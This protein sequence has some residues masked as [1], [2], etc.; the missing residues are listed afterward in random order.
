M[1]NE[2]FRMSSDSFLLIVPGAVLV[3]GNVVQNT[4]MI[5][6]A[7]II[8]VL[9]LVRLCMKEFHRKIALAFFYICMFTFLTGGIIIDYFQQNEE[10]LLTFTKEEY[11]CACNAL[12]I[13]Y[14]FLWIGYQWYGI[15]KLHFADCCLSRQVKQLFCDKNINIKWVQ[16]IS[17]YLLI[18]STVCMA[19]FNMEKLR[20]AMANGYMS[21]YTDY[22]G[23]AW[24]SR[25]EFVCQVSFFAGLASKPSKKR[26]YGISMLGLINPVIE[27]MQGTRGHFVTKIL[28][29]ALYLYS[30]DDIKNKN[31][32]KI[33]YRKK[34]QK[35]LAAGAAAC[36]AGLPILTVYGVTRS[37]GIYAGPSGILGKVIDFFDQ[38]GFSFSLIGYAVRYKGQLPN[39]FYSMGAFIDQFFTK[40]EFQGLEDYALHAHSFGSIITY[41]AAKSAY[42]N[43]Y[44]MGS[45]YIAELYYDFGYLGVAAV[46][47][48]VGAFMKRMTDWKKYSVLGKTVCFFLYNYFLG[49]PRGAFAHPFQRLIAT[50]T[51][52]TFL[53]I[54]GLSALKKCTN[55]S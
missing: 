28:F 5:V 45:S 35:L 34:F 48:P 36:I 18:A 21:L 49:M 51:L 10:W 1:R 38:Q 13:S 19:F 11:I 8:Q 25:I 32:S 6:W 27:F 46:N 16:D 40:G 47:L 42:F 29:L 37:G 3:I 39:Q 7:L 55:V 2:G 44:G 52:F 4:G 15:R 31:L 9:M 14:L 24:A 23:S 53:F 50:T 33:Q 26:L 54:F 41:K 20:Y 12:Y 17:F 30:Y 43:G 22:T